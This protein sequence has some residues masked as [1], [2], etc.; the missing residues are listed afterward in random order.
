MNLGCFCVQ[1]IVFVFGPK[2]VCLL[3]SKQG[4]QSMKIEPQNEGDPN[5]FPAN[6]T[7]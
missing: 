2:G 5:M 6:E 1:K 4:G 3:V 7:N